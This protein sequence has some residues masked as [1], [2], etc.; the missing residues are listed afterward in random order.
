[1]WTQLL[2][3]H[4]TLDGVALK[5]VPTT[6]LTHVVLIYAKEGVPAWQQNECY[7][8]HKSFLLKIIYSDVSHYNYQ[9]F[10]LD[11][12]LKWNIWITK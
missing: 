5:C 2:E 10:A 11:F 12:T 9:Y 3:S 8:L 7:I 4:S 1:M 6:L